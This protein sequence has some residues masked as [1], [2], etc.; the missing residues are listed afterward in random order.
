MARPRKEI[1]STKRPV[2][3]WVLSY[4]DMTTNMLTFFI[5]LVGFASSRDAGLMATGT[6]SFIRALDSFGLPGL[7][8]GSPHAINKGAPLPNFPI[9]GRYVE[10]AKDIFGGQ[11]LTDLPKDR[12]REATIDYLRADRAV[13][14]PTPVTFLP[15]TAE[16]DP[17][18]A[19]ALDTI[20]E[21]AQ[22]GVSHVGIEAHVSGPDD[23]WT[24][25]ALRAAA[26]A[27]Y[28]H[29]RGKVAYDRI[30]MAGYGRFRPV[31]AATAKPERQTNDRISVLLS[32]KPL[33]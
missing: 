20:A 6:G 7:L 25:S 31:A 21:L 2:P 29:D 15:G 5:L 19:K 13:A 24:L 23:G 14:L 33:Y 32:P 28:L 11:T 18:S 9:P 10:P 27:R 26:V 3:I 4:G 22:Q 16:L 8:Q 30:A 1:P 17:A 12:L